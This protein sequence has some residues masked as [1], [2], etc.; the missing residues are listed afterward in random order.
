MSL[1]LGN[2]V[3]A[4]RLEKVVLAQ[5]VSRFLSSEGRNTEEVEAATN[6]ARALAQDLSVQVRETLAF[7]LRL[8]RH[9][10][11]D[12]AAR[13]ASDVE[14]VSGAFVETTFALSDSQWAGLIPHLEEHAHIRLARRSDIGEQ[15]ALA[16]VASGSGKTVTYV[17]KN[18]NIKITSEICDKTLQRFSIEQ[19]VMDAMAHREDLPIAVAERIIAL[20]SEQCRQVLLSNYAL[21]DQVVGELLFKTQNETLWRQIAQAGPAQVHGYVVDLKKQGRLS[22]MLTLEMVERGSFQF[23]GS[24]L[25]IEAGVTLGEVRAVLEQ[26]ELRALLTLIQKAGYGKTSAQRIFRI[27]KENEITISRT[28]S[29]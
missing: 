22:E 16:L 2:L 8:C 27:L 6:I 25:A 28:G 1:A 23:L 29:H 5:R 17:M 10:P 20:V 15:T 7:E 24:A 14:S 26:G 21:P 13:I 18:I 4:D 19:G 12:L 11:Q 3:N 9:L